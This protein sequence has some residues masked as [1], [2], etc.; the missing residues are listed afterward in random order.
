[1][2]L[3]QLVLVNVV[4]VHQHGGNAGF[5]H[6]LIAQL[7]GIIGVDQRQLLIAIEAGAEVEAV[8]ASHALAAHLVEHAVDAKGLGNRAAKHRQQHTGQAAD[9][10]DQLQLARLVHAHA[11]MVDA[12]KAPQ[13]VCP[14]ARLH[15]IARAHGLF[16]HGHHLGAEGQ[17]VPLAVQRTHIALDQRALILAHLDKVGLDGIAQV[18]AAVA[19]R[20]HAAIIIYN[21]I[22]LMAGFFLIAR[23]NN[24]H[25][26]PSAAS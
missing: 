25:T 14:E 16:T 24:S 17:H 11:R 21:A 7:H 15:L 3:A 22:F 8:D 26:F 19:A 12:R 13:Q 18:L 10:D 23:F 20:Q 2:A 1:M 6:D 9:I 5:L 4:S